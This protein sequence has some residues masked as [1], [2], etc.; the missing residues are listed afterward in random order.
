MWIPHIPHA[1][2]LSHCLMSYQVSLLWTATLRPVGNYWTRY[3]TKRPINLYCV[4]SAELGYFVFRYRLA[5]NLV[6]MPLCVYWHPYS[7][8][9]L[10]SVLLVQAQ[11][12]WK[13]INNLLQCMSVFTCSLNAQRI[14]F[15]Y[16]YC[17]VKGAYPS[18]CLFTVINHCDIGWRVS[19][20]WL[21]NSA[22]IWFPLLLY[23]MIM[24][25]IFPNLVTWPRTAWSIPQST[26]IECFSLH[27][28]S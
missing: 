8:T 27:Y 10:C 13:N 11:I 16:C 24:V 12:W 28:A 17:L 21:S 2:K 23:Q 19:T 3:C 25:S 1:G 14:F 6:V 15:G 26:I 20:D 7:V 18:G 22:H 4:R 5:G 9:L